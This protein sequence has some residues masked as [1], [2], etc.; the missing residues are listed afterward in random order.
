L[1]CKNCGLWENN[2]SNCIRGY[3]S[4]TPRI[5]FVGEAPGEK[6]DQQGIPFIGEAGDLLKEFIFKFNIPYEWYFLTN[7]CR[8]RPPSNR[9][10]TKEERRLQ[11]EARDH[12]TVR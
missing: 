6:E 11:P 12:S 10:P 7:V 8:C 3:G 9:N 2:I 5:V 4:S 1:E